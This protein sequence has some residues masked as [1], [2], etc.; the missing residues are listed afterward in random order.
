MLS[1][2]E[3]IHL[4]GVLGDAIFACFEAIAQ[5]QGRTTQ[6]TIEAW[7]SGYIAERIIDP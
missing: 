1:D 6:D 4:G 2:D 3:Q 5:V 7:I